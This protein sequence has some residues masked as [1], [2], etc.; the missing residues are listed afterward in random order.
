MIARMSASELWRC[1]RSRSQSKDIHI[2]GQQ[3]GYDVHVL[4]RALNLLYDGLSTSVVDA[5]VTGLMS[6]E[7]TDSVNAVNLPKTHPRFNINV[8]VGLVD[9]SNNF[10]L[11]SVELRS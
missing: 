1:E 7:S 9:N 11:T 4:I 8:F 5:E 2:L 10:K 3:T 6:A